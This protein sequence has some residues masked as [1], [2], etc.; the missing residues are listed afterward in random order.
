MNHISNIKCN[1]NQ[2]NTKILSLDKAIIIDVNGS[3]WYDILHKR[4]L[5]RILAKNIHS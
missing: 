1:K 2:I 3:T 5:C 4:G